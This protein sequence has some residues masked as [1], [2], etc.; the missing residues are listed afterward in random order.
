MGHRIVGHLK[1]YG[2][3]EGESLYSIK[4]GAMQHEYYIEGQDEALV[5]VS[6]TARRKS[7]TNPTPSGN[8]SLSLWH[9]L[10]DSRRK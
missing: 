1:P 8:P 4:R 6:T 9:T 7:T 3:Y 10:S 5:C 2:L